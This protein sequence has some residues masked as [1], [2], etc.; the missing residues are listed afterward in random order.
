M[1]YFEANKKPVLSFP[2]VSG[3]IAS[4]NS[5][6]AGLPLKNH[7]VAITAVQAGS[8]TPSPDNVRA[9]SGWNGAVIG[10]GTNNSFLPY[11]EGLLNGTYGFFDIGSLNWVYSGNMFTNSEMRTI[12][13]PATSNSNTINGTSNFY[14]VTSYND[15]DDMCLAVSTAGN[16]FI[17]NSDYTDVNTF[18]TAMSGVYL[19]YELATP[20]TPTITQAEIDTLI[21]AFEADL[22]CVVFGQTVYGGVLDCKSGVVTVTHQIIQIKDINL[23]YSSNSGGY[24]YSETV[25]K[26]DGVM[27][28]FSDVLQTTDVNLSIMPN[29]SVR[30]LANGRNIYIKATDY[31]DVASLKEAIGDYYI[32]YELSTPTTIQLSP[33]QLETLLAENN[34]WA[35]T[36]D[37]TLQYIKLG[38]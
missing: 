1:A 7:E 6:Y 21:S 12:I 22:N 19:I 20:T 8:G 31:T 11:F 32:V 18:K 33:V 15:L 37:T 5:Q 36:G 17:K 23:R 25:D 26:S 35:D 4:F 30:G 14:R 27:N 13:K 10:N 29:Y 24:F 16:I 38:G 34:I 9:I 3:A 2:T 28:L